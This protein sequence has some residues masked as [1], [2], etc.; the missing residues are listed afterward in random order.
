MSKFLDLHEL[1]EDERIR[2]IGETVMRSGKSA[3]V[4]TDSDP[5]KAER[6]AKKLRERFPGI[7]VE[8]PFDGPVAGVR[9]ITVSP[10]TP[11]QA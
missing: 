1:P 5:G 11:G 8:G 3:A 4:P 2:V 9:T 6:Y 10:P 7:I